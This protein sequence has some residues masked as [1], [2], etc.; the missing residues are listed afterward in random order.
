MAMQE[1]AL[2]NAAIAVAASHYS[3]WQH[4]ADTVSRRYHR[5]ASKALRDRFIAGNN[6]HRQD[7]LATMLLLVSFEVFSGSSRWKEHYNAIR[8]WIRSRGDCSDLDPFLKTWVCLLDTQSSL[9]LGQPA[10][11]ELMSWLDV[12]ANSEEQGDCV[13]ALFGCSS[14][15][16]K[17]MLPASAR[18]PDTVG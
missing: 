17:L 1:P 14:K 16:V 13:D 8:G 7:I 3:R 5:A 6:I 18:P 9:N 15:L 12:P 11:P 4:T 2:L 10:M